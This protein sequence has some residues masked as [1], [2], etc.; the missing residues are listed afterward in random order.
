ME[1]VFLNVN[2][3]IESLPYYV[4]AMRDTMMLVVVCKMFDLADDTAASCFKCSFFC[5]VSRLD[6]VHAFI[7]I[8]YQY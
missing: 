4:Y 8:L 1:Q 6:L 2:S 5:I 7:L 3:S